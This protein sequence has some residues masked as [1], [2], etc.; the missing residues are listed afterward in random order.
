MFKQVT[1][2]VTCT[3]NLVK[4]GHVVETCERTDK[5]TDK[6]AYR[7]AGRNT[8]LTHRG[9]VIKMLIAVFE[10]HSYD[11]RCSR[12]RQTSPPMQPPGK[13]DET[14][15]SSLILAHLLHYEKK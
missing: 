9:E 12:R 5:H 4:F 1:A 8:L 15:A 6:E 10:Q 13:L 11:T 14:Y 2:I 3:E 7:Q